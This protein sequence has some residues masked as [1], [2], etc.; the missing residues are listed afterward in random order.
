[1]KDRNTV[2]LRF[3]YNQ[4]QGHYFSTA[5][6]KTAGIIP[7]DYKDQLETFINSLDK[8]SK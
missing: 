3:Q 8:N 7:S 6:N 4:R 5:Y 2:E 1:M